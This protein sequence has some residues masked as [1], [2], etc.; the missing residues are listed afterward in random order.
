MVPATVPVLVPVHHRPRV[1]SAQFDGKSPAVALLGSRRH[2]RH[3][4]HLVRR[5]QNC[6]PL[7]L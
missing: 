7:H 6:E 2:G 1:L 4:V 3:L 5:E